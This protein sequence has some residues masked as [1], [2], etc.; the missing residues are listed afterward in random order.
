[1]AKDHLTHTHISTFTTE[2]Q[3]LVLQLGDGVGIMSATGLFM[4]YDNCASTCEHVLLCF[5]I[6]NCRWCGEIKAHNIT[7]PHSNRDS[8]SRQTMVWIWSPCRVPSKKWGSPTTSAATQQANR[9]SSLLFTN[10]RPASKST[11]CVCVS[12]A[13]NEYLV[14]FP[15]SHVHLGDY[16]GSS[17]PAA[18]I[19][20]AWGFPLRY[21]LARWRVYVFMAVPRLF[22]E[23]SHRLENH[24][25]ILPLV[26]VAYPLRSY[27]WAWNICWVLSIVVPVCPYLLLINVPHGW[28]IYCHITS[29]IVSICCYYPWI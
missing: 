26:F 5:T 3:F 24:W 1:M 11:W 23:P 18:E 13:H 6:A 7:Q 29:A 8:Y 16:I 14:G 17:T 27:E 21:S 15:F 2:E 28:I 10:S 4:A 25:W 19:I 22:L 12:M 20:Q 9:G